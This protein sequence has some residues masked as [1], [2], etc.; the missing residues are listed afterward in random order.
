MMVM[1]V[2]MVVVVVMMMVV[3]VVLMMMIMV[4]VM[5]VIMMVMMMMMIILV[6]VVVIVVTM[7][8]TTTMTMMMTK[9]LTLPSPIHTY[10]AM[11][12]GVRKFRWRV[13]KWS[14]SLDSRLGR[15]MLNSATNGFFF[16]TGRGCTPRSISM[17]TSIPE[18]TSRW[19]RAA[20]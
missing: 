8:T 5:V 7:T 17:E 20:R 10:L 15:F 18:G 4:V 16:W 19:D 1:M 3:V 12:W 6:E 14:F 13:R 11:S 2:I 9:P